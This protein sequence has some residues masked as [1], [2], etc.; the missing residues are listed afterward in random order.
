MRSIIAPPTGRRGSP[1]AALLLVVA[2]VLTACGSPDADEEDAAPEGAAEG[3]P[4]AEEPAED[5]D[6]MPEAEPVEG[7]TLVFG[8]IFSIENTNPHPQSG[9]TFNFREAIF[10]TLVKLDDERLPEPWLAESWDLSDDGLTL[11]MTL[12]DDVAFHSGAPFDADA[13]AWNIEYAADPDSGVQAGGQIRDVEVEVLSEFEIALSFEGPKPQIYSALVGIPMIDPESD[14]DIAV[15]GTG[16]FVLDDFTPG[17]EMR[18]VRN[19]DYWIDGAPILDELVIRVIPDESSLVLG[20]ETGELDVIIQPPMNE[21]QRIQDAGFEL[22]NLPGPGNFNYLVSTVDEPLDDKLVRQ[23]LSFAI[24]REH[25]SEVV[26]FGLSDPTCI[27]FPPSSPVWT[28]ELDSCEFDLDRAGEL[29]DEAGVGDGFEVT[30]HVATTAVQEVGQFTEAYQS[31]LA[32]IGIAAEIERVEPNVWLDLIV[33]SEFPGLLGHAYQFGDLDPAL[34]FGAHPFGVEQN[35]SRFES[36]EYRTLVREAATEL[37]NDRRIELYREV[38][39]LIKDEAF[40]LPIGT[41]VQ[42]YALNERVNGFQVNALN[43]P[44]FRQASLSD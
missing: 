5:P 8:Q 11:T 16:P 38:T 3:A 29:L 35:A 21:A 26:T 4:E 36:E 6:E 15:G 10:D 41:R 2:L 33:N 17:N 40:I 13:A 37:D 22:V 32:E 30:I 1:I 34:L 27:V 12:R 25:F 39:E 43:M 24:D 42:L 20:L 19:E 18:L 28:E 23:A 9:N 14:I 31:D 7:G 44:D